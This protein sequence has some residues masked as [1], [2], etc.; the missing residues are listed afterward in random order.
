MKDKELEK[1]I[2]AVLKQ[3]DKLPRA[4]GVTSKGK[5]VTK[6]KRTQSAL[7]ASAKKFIS[8]IQRNVRDGKEK[9][10]RYRKS[11]NQK[12]TYYPGN[13]RKSNKV[14][15]FKKAHPL[16]IFVGPKGYRGKS[17]S[18]GTGNKA[19]GYYAPFVHDGTENHTP[20]PFVEKGF[21]SAKNEVLKD[22][23]RRVENIFRYYAKQKGLGKI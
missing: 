2:R 5:V 7:R 12:I 10:Y 8:P 23:K 9:H 13:L 19:D 11:D 15:K 14:M 20:N 4:I 16:A 6:E 18:F 1:D 3:L 17:T 21:N 22:L